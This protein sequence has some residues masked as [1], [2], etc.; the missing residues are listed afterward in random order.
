MKK[1]LIIGDLLFYLALPYLIWKFGQAPLGDYYAMLLSTVPGIFY[2][3]FRFL[4]ERQFNV[5]GL[6]ILS[7]LVVGTTVDVISG[8]AANMQWNN[9]YLSLGFGCFWILT[10]L[11]R[12]PLALY[13]AIDIAYMQGQSRAKSKKLYMTPK[14]L[15][16]FYI[17]SGIF[18][19]RSFLSGGLRSYLI[20]TFGVANYDSILFYMKV[21]GWCFSVIIFGAFIILG[22]KMNEQAESSDMTKKPA[23][24]N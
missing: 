22:I 18:A 20:Q 4:S 6:F 19:L 11:I 3:I 21:Y 1:H 17:I 12:R 2:T 24:A 13:F 14:L 23:E 7:S 8:S 9:V 15:P 16:W 10:M 5:T